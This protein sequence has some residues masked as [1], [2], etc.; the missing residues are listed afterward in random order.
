VSV[1][2]S[3]Y[4]AAPDRLAHLVYSNILFSQT[5]AALRCQVTGVHP[6]PNHLQRIWGAAKAIWSVGYN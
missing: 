1:E 5:V 4:A 6:R 3:I 2:T